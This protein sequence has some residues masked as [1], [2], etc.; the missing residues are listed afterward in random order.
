MK[1]AYLENRQFRF[2]RIIIT[3]T[4]FGLWAIVNLA[5]EKQRLSEALRDV[6]STFTMSDR[7]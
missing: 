5:K 3:Q 7:Q 2:Y 6:Q 1:A 4:L